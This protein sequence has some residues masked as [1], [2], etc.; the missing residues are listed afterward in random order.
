MLFNSYIFIF[1]FLPLA[2]AGYFLLNAMRKV[3]AAKWWLV[4]SSLFF[5]SYWNVIYLPLII[6]SMVANYAISQVL[7]RGHGCWGLSH[8][9]IFMLGVT[10]NILL[11]VYFKY[12][13]FFI[14]NFNFVFNADT[15]LLH[16]V[17]PLAISFFTLQQVAFL[18]DSYEGLVEEHHALD[19]ALFVS[20]FPQLIAG[21]IVHHQEMMPQFARLKNKLI[22]FE[23]IAKGLL[24]FAIGLVKKV[25]IADSLSLWVADGS[26]ASES[27]TL[28]PAWVTSLAYTFQIYFDF[29]GYADMAIGAALLFNIRLPINFN[30]PYKATGVIDYWQRWHITLTQFI[31][32]YVYTPILRS[33]E[34]IS[35]GKAM[36]ATFMAM[37]IS[38]LWHGAGWTFVVWGVLHGI[39]LVV[40]HYWN[41]LRYRLSTIVAWLITFNFINITGVF[42]RARDLDS[43]F[44][45]LKGMFGL[46]GVVIPEQLQRFIHIDGLDY[47]AFF[48]NVSNQLNVFL[49]MLLAL[50]LSLCCKN[51]TEII[52]SVKYNMGTLLFNVALFCLAM[53]YFNRATVFLYFNF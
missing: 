43:A 13:D 20:F 51:S 34:R 46:N 31:T 36:F 1:L 26:D 37:F 17:L 41:K 25:V 24:I 27:L 4:A 12:M 50:L 48:T 3:Q 2:F 21:P 52:D 42:F 7:Q 23:N 44:K 30:S 47:G 22:H 39:A 8:R 11:L 38:G 28:I 16:L 29:S 10:A 33:F 45:V 40:N 6:G 49:W 18:V 14:Q 9:G 32:T 15:P 5:Y 19:Y 35:F 53:L